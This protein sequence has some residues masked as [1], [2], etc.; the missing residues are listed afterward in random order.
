MGVAS[1]D[2][3]LGGLA[4]GVVHEVVPQDVLNV[5]AAAG[6]VGALALR[7][8][9]GEATGPVFWCAR[10]DGLF[11]AGAL[12]GR[13][14]VNMGAD[15]SRFLLASGRR[16][17]DVLWALEEALRSGAVALAVGEVASAS[18]V[19]TRRLSL[20]A[21]DHGVPAVLLR[22]E[23]GLGPSAARTRWRV[24]AAQSRP[25]PFAPTAPGRPCWQVALVK[26]WREQPVSRILEWDHE[27]RCFLDI[28]GLADH[29][30][31]THSGGAVLPF[32]CT[33]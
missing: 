31:E 1:F 7:R 25:P 10:H 12:S 4:L 18:L 29:L 8:L 26:G 24:A 17:E 3:A 16:D 33:G 20:A 13:G 6:F 23:R 21:R 22:T 11:E 2:A 19:A 9:A 28:A 30:P 27:T 14:L 15:P 5:G 32:L